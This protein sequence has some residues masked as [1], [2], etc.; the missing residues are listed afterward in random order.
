MCQTLLNLGV[1]QL[2][3]T[4]RSV[5]TSHSMYQQT[6]SGSNRLKDFQICLSFELA[7]RIA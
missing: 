4:S 6:Q 7:G 3:I 2:A 1:L 5:M